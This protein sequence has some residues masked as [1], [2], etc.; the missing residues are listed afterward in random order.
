MEIVYLCK[1]Q[2][3]CLVILMFISH[4][5]ITEGNKVDKLTEKSSCNPYFD[6]MFIMGEVTILFDMITMYTVN[7]LDTVSR[8]WNGLFHYLFFASYELFVVILFSY[9]LSVS[10]RLP[11]KWWHKVLC[12]GPCVI[13][14]V[15][16]ALLMPQIHYD[17]GVHS[18][19]SMGAAVYSCFVVIGIYLVMTLFMFF[20]LRRYIKKNHVRSLVMSMLGSVAVLA[21]Q[22]VFPDLLM[23][24]L[25]VMLIIIS[26]Y[27]GMENPS[28][29]TVE[30]YHEEMLLGFSTLLE[31]RMVVPVAISD[32]PQNML[33]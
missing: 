17:K 10:G 21:L 23:S 29:K 18:N 25:A 3:C 2:V 11:K 16:T 20:R 19:Y 24:S 22:M 14:L 15:V 4:I 26:V 8:F 27:L 31:K 32:V 7:H 33:C 13:S 28:V 1:E 9:W 30:I 6:R 12:Y 5:F